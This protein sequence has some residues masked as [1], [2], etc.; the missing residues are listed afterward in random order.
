MAGG[1]DQPARIVPDCEPAPFAAVDRVE[2]LDRLPARQGDEQ[3]AAVG[4]RRDRVRARCG[5]G[6]A[7]ALVEVN[8]PDA[9]DLGPGV[10]ERHPGEAVAM[11]ARGRH[12]RRDVVVRLA[13]RHPQLIRVCG[14]EP[15][16]AQDRA[17][18]GQ[19]ADDRG[20]AGVDHR[21]VAR[22][23]R[24]PR[25]HPAAGVGVARQHREHIQPPARRI[26]RERPRVV[27]HGDARRH[28][29]RPQVDPGDRVLA[30]ERDPG[31][32]AVDQHRCRLVAHADRIDQPPGVDIEQTEAVARHLGDQHQPLAGPERE[33]RGPSAG[34]DQ[35]PGARAV[36][37]EQHRLHRVR[38][39]ARDPHRVGIGERERVGG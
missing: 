34:R 32:V 36:G 38:R 17:Q 29:P 20:G 33:R 8:E 19:V 2:H 7:R 27:A 6:G 39:R 26:E 22:R 4:G 25:L 28:P 30:R 24:R 5:A 35:R 21:H 23:R 9:R 3:Q 10:V 37:A 12:H 18:L 13:A 31:R 15:E 11:G 1:E 14:V 16:P